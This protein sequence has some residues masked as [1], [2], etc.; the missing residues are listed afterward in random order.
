MNV[1]SK[2]V[3]ALR[4][5][6][7]CISKV[8]RV[9]LMDQDTQPQ[10]LFVAGVGGRMRAHSPPWQ[11]FLQH[12]KYNSTEQLQELN[13]QLNI[14][15]PFLALQIFIFCW[16]DTQ[17]IP[18]CFV[19]VKAHRNLHFITSYICGAGCLTIFNLAKYLCNQRVEVLGW[20]RLTSLDFPKKPCQILFLKRKK[21]SMRITSKRSCPLTT[22]TL[23]QSPNNNFHHFLQT[24]E[25]AFSKPWT[26]VVWT[27]QQQTYDKKKKKGC[28]NKVKTRAMLT[29]HLNRNGN[30]DRHDRLFC[31]KANQS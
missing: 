27:H 4:Y 15:T 13:V 31:P 14:L 11:L 29:T 3:G 8:S 26:S 21:Q 12:L 22:Y 19:N 2:N 1:G 25:P 17:L 28:T 23:G 24:L 16:P 20:P 5:W 6:D 10:S 18:T 7:L 9:L 30:S